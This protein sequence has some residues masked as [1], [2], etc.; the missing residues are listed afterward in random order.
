ML[1]RI[2]LFLNPFSDGRYED[3]SR[4]WKKTVVSDFT[5]GLIVAML[6]IPMN[7]GFAIASGLHPVHGL[8]AGALACLLG[9]LFGGSKYQVYG[10]TAAYIPV[11][12][13]IMNEYGN[14]S[15][16]P[17]SPEYIAGYYFLI[18]CSVL[19]GV[20]LIFMGLTGLGDFINKVPHSI[21]VGFTIGIALTIAFTQIGDVLGLTVK[22]PNAF[23]QKISTIWSN[24]DQFNIY[25]LLIAVGTFLLCKYLLRYAA[26]I[27]G[28]VI[29][30]AIGIVLNETILHD[31]ELQ[32]SIHKYGAIPTSDL[33][34]FTPPKL[35]EMNVDIFGL[36]YFTAAVV[37]VAA[38][39]SLLC[40]NMADRMAENKG[41]PYNPNK[42]LFGQGMVNIFAP[43]FN[44]FTCTGALARTATNIKVGGVT[45]LAGIMNCCL[46]L[47]MVYFLAAHLDEVPMACIGGI[48]AYIAFN[49]VKKQEI[50]TVLRMNRFH[51]FLMILTA[52]GVFVKDFLS[53]VLLGLAVY[54]LLKR[55]FDKPQETAAA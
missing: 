21:V 37:F 7:M 30:V 8:I 13:A 41:T 18:L 9:A 2:K 22:I 26:Y 3:M 54:A 12:A 46:K 10:P 24:L 4:G 49:M 20:I 27:P 51:V 6:A 34:K 1:D 50:Q 42:E 52:I 15:R 45:P 43:L 35:S 14:G 19:G 33:F 28:P 47:A 44:G 5:A 25:A 17:T 31:E 16:D 39:E 23:L 32:A 55:F 40:S 29:A 38:I 36:V 48:L 11:L 53:G